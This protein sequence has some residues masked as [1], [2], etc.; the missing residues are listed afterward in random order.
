MKIHFKRMASMALIF[1]VMLSMLP[2]QVFAAGADVSSKLTDFEVSVTQDG[3]KIK[4]TDEIS[5]E[6]SIQVKFSFR[7]P[8]I[9]D[10]EPDYVQQD[11]E[12]Y[13]QIAKG[14][15]L[16]SGLGPFEL[17]HKK[18]K[19]GTLTLETKD[20]TKELMARIVFDGENDVFNPSE[21]NWADVVCSFNADLSYDASGGD[22]TVGGHEVILLEKKF[23][24]N[25]PPPPILING[26]KEGTRTGQFVDWKV[27]VEATQGAADG[28]MSGYVFSDALSRVG[29][30]EPGSFKV[31]ELADGSDATAPAEDFSADTSV[32][33]YT[34]ENGTEG[35]RY[36]FFRTKI[37][38]NAFYSNT[39]QTITNIA[40]VNDGK[41]DWTLEAGSVSF[42]SKWIEKEASEVNQSTGEI[43]WSITANQLGATL[44]EAVIEDA[45]DEKVIWQSAEWS[46]WDEA[47]KKWNTAVSIPREADNKSY[48]LGDISTPVLLKIKA[49]V[50]TAN[51]NIGHTIQT[52]TNTASI[53]W[54]DRPGVNTNPVI[55][56]IGMNPISKTVGSAGYDPSTHT[57]PWEVTVEK[58]DVNLN[59]RVMDLLVYGTGGFDV[60]ANYAISDNAAA[61]LSQVSAADIKLLTPRYQ[62]KYGGNFVSPDGLKIAV[63]TLEKDGKAV[64]DLLVVTANN[65]TGIDV[66]TK[67]QSFSFDT[68]VTDPAV[69]AK[70]GSSD[71]YNTATL[72]SANQRVNSATNKAS[73][74]SKML[75]KDML[76]ILHAKDPDAN[77]NAQGVSSDKGFNYL[78]KSAVFRLVVN[79]NKIAGD[80]TADITT[81]PDVS[82]GK[83]TLEDN[84][85]KGWEFV[86]IEDGVPFLLYEG[87]TQ[88]GGAV[89]AG[90]V[91]SDADTFVEADFTNSGKV[92][93]VFSEL[94]DTYVILLKAKL[95]DEE[96]KK[97]FDNNK[98]F[99]VKN[100]AKLFAENWTAGSSDWQDIAIKSQI[101]SKTIPQNAVDGVLTW[102]VEYKPYEIA[103]EG[104]MIEDTLPVGIDLRMDASGN[105]DLTDGNIA[106]REITLKEDGSY[107]SGATVNLVLEENIF[108]DSFKR[109]L[110]IALPDTQKG[111]RV[112]YKTDITGDCDDEVTNSVRLSSGDVTP[113]LVARKYVV[114]ESDVSATMQK[115]G[116]IEITKTDKGS[117][118]LS[119]AA[120]ALYTADGEKIIRSGVTGQD[121]KLCLR[122]LVEGEYLLKEVAP[123]TGYNLLDRTYA[124]E[125]Y[126]SGGTI[127][128]SI[129]GKIGSGSNKIA[130]KNI[131]T[132]TVGNLSVEK[133]VAGNDA[134]DKKEFEFS[135]QID[136]LNSTY[137]YVGNGGKA[138]GSLVF[139]DG[140]AVFT[141]KD[142]E[143]IHILDLPKGLSYTVE[144][145]DYSKEGYITEK[146][147]D[148]GSILEDDTQSAVFTNTKDKKS[149]GGSGSSKPGIPIEEPQDPKE[150]PNNPDEVQNPKEE[151]KN[152]EG[153]P[154]TPDSKTSGTVQNGNAAQA[155]SG[156]QTSSAKGTLLPKTGESS[157]VVFYLLGAGFIL[158]GIY[159]RKREKV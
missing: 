67:N 7:V 37:N 97:Y 99:T 115:K 118:L 5:S 23:I 130:I 63:H 54:K 38:D 50:D 125:V 71:I 3:N 116:W 43:T 61:D 92:S 102:T 152:P 73:C 98:D 126:K 6:K 10:G 143:R 80:M 84:L 75:A 58:S 96:A 33:S 53:H 106:M 138:D 78:N 34:F 39:N 22:D 15:T 112:V 147:G 129:D 59:L 159:F 100:E 28:D 18:I 149:K 117:E 114:D 40:K 88:S 150:I 19:V 31:G 56:N 151:L 124:V 87:T 49:K 25:V 142:G 17:K 26:K 11:D 86:D 119:G 70:N 32:L 64:A 42:E 35:T 82:L 68:I 69:Y 83:V 127:T 121:G 135:V 153:Q 157:N 62:Q 41:K 110:K 133:H 2:F 154:D 146:T 8:V 122:G 134:D 144:E 74:N 103:H 9:G 60:N 128:A 107:E 93:F 105:L 113:D 111:Y 65:G 109:M 48:N 72:F 89:L 66:L 44:E 46:T 137:Q 156:Q 20:S 94:K 132:G 95:S 24:V 158:A 90:N 1:F 16:D 123:P 27:R 81:K 13:F 77:K 155:N 85:P 4:E 12:A 55:T 108:Y 145:L 139:Q 21:E 76:S 148:T 30:Y 79:A 36:L 131:K 91:V 57:I 141:L 14:F 136:T 104:S 51:Y 140:N 29:T 47:G 120:F 101:L 52:V 45:L